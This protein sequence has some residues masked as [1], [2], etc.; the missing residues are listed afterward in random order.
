MYY[1]KKGIEMALIVNLNS[2]DYIYDYLQLGVHYFLV[3]APSFSCRQALTLSYQQLKEFKEKDERIKVFVLVN[4]LVEQHLLDDLKK[5]LQCLNDCH[6][7]GILFQDFGVLDICQEAGYHF[8]KIYAPDTLNTN[9]MT[10]NVLKE[11]GVDGAFLARE[12]PLEEK[13][14][15]QQN[16]S[17]KTMVQIHGVEYMAYSKRKLLSNYKEVTGYTFDVSKEENIEIQANGTDSLCH[18]YEDDYGTHVLS[19]KQLCTLDVL[20]HFIDFDYLMIDGQYLSDI[21]LLEVVNLYVQANEALIN[22]T[23]NKESIE[24]KQL[25]YRLTPHIEYYHSFLFDSTVYKIADVRKREEDER[26]KSN[27]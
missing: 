22:H 23:Y 17:L 19:S 20:N 24:L 12:I 7:D 1:S 15:I 3:G 11:M 25:L 21:E 13:K 26:N 9:Y 8:E 5:H 10:L 27:H 14:M 4:A 2:L 18:I 6:I 16:V